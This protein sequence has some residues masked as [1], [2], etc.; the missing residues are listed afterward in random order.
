M[1]KHKVTVSITQLETIVY[2]LECLQHNLKGTRYEDL[3]P[4]VEDSLATLRVVK[5][6]VEPIEE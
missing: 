2:E 6:K 4:E 5:V 1:E 3:L